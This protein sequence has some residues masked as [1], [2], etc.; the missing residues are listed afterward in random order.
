MQRS[1]VTSLS[2]SDFTARYEEHLVEVRGL[3]RAT[4]ALHRWVVQ[5][6]LRYRFPNEQINWKDFSSVTALVS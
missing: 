6:L 5:K 4:C 3:S 1:I 2:V